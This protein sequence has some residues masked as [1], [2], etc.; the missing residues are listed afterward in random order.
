MVG[1]RRG[2][3]VI[4]QP[5][6]ILLFHLYAFPAEPNKGFCPAGRRNV[7]GTG[8]FFSLRDE[9]NRHE[10]R[11]VPGIPIQALVALADRFWKTAR[12]MWNALQSASQAWNL[13]V[14]DELIVSDL[15]NAWQV[16]WYCFRTDPGID[17]RER[18]ELEPASSLATGLKIGEIDLLELY[19]GM[20]EHQPIIA[21]F[22]G[23]KTVASFTGK[24]AYRDAIAYCRNPVIQ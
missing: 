16:F 8:W 22:D 21:V 18:M 9:C 10:S 5:V 1:C 2:D 7:R 12:T 3:Q 20:R 11:L 17:L 23:E 24:N 6:H 4:H 15:L 14:R 13:G 19:F